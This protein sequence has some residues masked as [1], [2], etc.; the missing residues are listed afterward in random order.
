MNRDGRM[1]HCLN[2]GESEWRK[3]SGEELIDIHWIAELLTES[4]LLSEILE[5]KHLRA[6]TI[7][8]KLE[9]FRNKFKAFIQ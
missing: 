5:K 2:I 9:V 6:L 8:I 1:E 7:G 3:E 4:V